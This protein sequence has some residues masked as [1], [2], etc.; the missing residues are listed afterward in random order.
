MV[1]ASEVKKG[2]D[3]DIEQRVSHQEEQ[4]HS[5]FTRLSEKDRLGER[6]DEVVGMRKEGKARAHKPEEFCFL[7]EI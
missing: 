1:I 5:F 7:F 4:G 2:G 3:I 6:R